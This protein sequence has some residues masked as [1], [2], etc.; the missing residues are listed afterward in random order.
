MSHIL[1]CKNC[2]KQL[3]IKMT[4]GFAHLKC[5]NCGCE[6]QL[7]QSSIKYYLLIPFISVGIAVWFRI[8]FIN[9][10]DIFIKTVVILFGSYLIYFLLCSLMVKL[11]LFK[12]CKREGD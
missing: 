11:K 1:V 9:T 8:M 5:Q 6:Y 4:S 12:Y 3:K 2:Q 10:E 7:D